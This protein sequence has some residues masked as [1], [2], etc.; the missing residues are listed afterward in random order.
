MATLEVRVRGVNLA[1]LKLVAKVM[2]AKA[3]NAIMAASQAVSA[4]AERVTFFYVVACLAAPVT[5]LVVVLAPSVYG[6]IANSDLSPVSSLALEVGSLVH[7]TVD[8]A[9]DAGD[10]I[11]GS[12]SFR[13]SVHG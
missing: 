5:H 12:K 11:G 8:A 1:I 13:A 4:I 6:S 10:D 3:I 2:G 7:I 9:T